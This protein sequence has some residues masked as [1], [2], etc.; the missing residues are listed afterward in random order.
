MIKIIAVSGSL[1]EKSTNTG[2]ISAAQTLKPGDMDIEYF[3]LKGIPIYDEDIRQKGIPE[4][5][6]ELT[7]KIR[8]ADGVLLAVPEYN[9]SFTAALKNVIDWI[10]R[11]PGQPLAGKPLAMMGASTGIFGTVRAQMHLRQPLVSLNARVMNKP[12]VYAGN[13][14]EKFD[15]DGNLTDDKTGEHLT[16][17]LEAFYIFIKKEK[18]T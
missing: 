14:G 3:A 9:Y 17:M 2:L 12:E 6:S 15:A 10:S 8:N 11:M 4:K 16:K 5:V 1:R 13:S 7:E 18:R